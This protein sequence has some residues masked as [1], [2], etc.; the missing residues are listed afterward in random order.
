MVTSGWPPD[1]ETAVQNHNQKNPNSYQINGKLY[2]EDEFFRI[3]FRPAGI[4]FPCNN[5]KAPKNWL[6]YM[7]WKIS[8]PKL[9]TFKMIP[10]SDNIID[11]HAIQLKL[12]NI[13][14]EQFIINHIPEFSNNPDL[15]VYVANIL[16]QS[17]FGYIPAAINKYL[18][19][20]IEYPVNIISLNTAED[21]SQ[22][23]ITSSNLLG[24]KNWFVRVTIDALPT[25]KTLFKS[26]RFSYLEE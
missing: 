7:L 6:Y 8:V 26:N 1:I 2:Q 18:A 14:T 16:N 24:P 4:Q 15:A 17:N 20:Y 11:K 25:N 22:L 3:S 12:Q 13:I 23:D 5:T 19:R 10:E 21:L 9:L